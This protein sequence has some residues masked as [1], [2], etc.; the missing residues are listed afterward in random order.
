MKKATRAL[1]EAE[2]IE[3][4]KLFSCTPAIADLRTDRRCSLPLFSVNISHQN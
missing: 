4:Q 2:R 3:M 1:I